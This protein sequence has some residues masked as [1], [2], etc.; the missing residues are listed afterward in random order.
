[1]SSQ[2]IKMISIQPRHVT[3]PGSQVGHSTCVLAAKERTPT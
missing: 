1:M 2:P 3:F